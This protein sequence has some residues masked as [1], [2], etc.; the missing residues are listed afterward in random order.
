[1]PEQTSFVSFLKAVFYKSCF[2]IGLGTISVW[3]FS[4]PTKVT[5][6]EPSTIQEKV[7]SLV[8]QRALMTDTVTRTGEQAGPVIVHAP[9]PILKTT[10]LS[11]VEANKDVAALAVSPDP[12]AS[13]TVSP[14]P[15]GVA[16][17][18]KEKKDGEEKDSEK[19]LEEAKTEEQLAQEAADAAAKRR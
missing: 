2:C 16:E 17:K 10:V 8:S 3:A 6:V 15:G 5:Q 1:M 12:N 4:H 18:D 9:N 19:K 14:T 13:P 11:S 7:N